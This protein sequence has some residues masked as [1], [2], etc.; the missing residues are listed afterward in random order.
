MNTLI[1]T[2]SA[3]ALFSISGFAMAEPCPDKLSAGDTYDCI[4]DEGAGKDFKAINTRDDEQARS[5]NEND[6][7]SAQAMTDETQ[8]QV[9]L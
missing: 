1:N 8:T 6:S 9:G 7:R 3:V 5:E 4:V 2:V